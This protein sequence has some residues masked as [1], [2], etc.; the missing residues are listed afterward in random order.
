MDESH[1]VQ[2]TATTMRVVEALLDHEV[3]GVTELA[4]ALDLSKGAV[5]NHL[6]TLEGLGFVVREDR[7]YRVG[8]KFLDLGTRA[9]GQLPVYRAARG[10]IARLA[11]A[12]GETAA[13][14]V[15]EHDQGAYTLVAGDEDDETDL[16]E[17]IR[18]PLT[19]DAAGKAILSTWPTDEVRDLL[20]AGDETLL[21]E[22]QTVR[23]QGVVFDR[24]P[25]GVRSVAA[26]LSGES[27]RAS[28][29]ICVAGPADRL[30][31]KRLE[32]DVTGLIVSSANSISVDLY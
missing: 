27:G 14:V 22:L 5:H 8:T 6:R 11:R 21:T 4:T 1:P 25:D 7:Q 23:E 2:A 13:L 15:P 16:R 12:S 18:R 20:S 28:G 30:S 29:A 32:E 19:A 31:G 26:P 3:A 9:R 17:G 24:A 10:E